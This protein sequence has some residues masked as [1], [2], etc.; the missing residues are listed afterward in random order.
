MCAVAAHVAAGRA[1]TI[2]LINGDRI[3]G[4]VVGQNDTSLFVR[5]TYRDSSIRYVETIPRSR[6]ARV[7]KTGDGLAAP[8]IPP[9]TLPAEE[10]KFSFS[11]PIDKRLVL[12]TA[13][14]KWNEGNM[15][16]AGNELTR[17]IT[18]SS[19]EE[20][21]A[22]SR[23]VEAK[24]KLSLGEMAARAHWEAAHDVRSGRGVHFPTA[25]RYELPYLL[26][27]L[28]E[29]YEAALQEEITVAP[30][31]RPG[32]ATPSAQR[33][34]EVPPYNRLTIANYLDRPHELR[35]SKAEANVL[36]AHIQYATSLLTERMRLDPEV[37]QNRTLHAA[38]TGQRIRLVALM[39]AASRLVLAPQDRARRERSVAS[40]PAEAAPRPTEPAVQQTSPLQQD[41]L[42]QQAIRLAREQEEAAAAG[43]APVPLPTGA[44]PTGLQPPPAPPSP[45]SQP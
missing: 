36:V 37:R 11:P 19:P 20:L 45:P 31:T 17:L 8:F 41:T 38:L 18:N 21:E 22:F 34:A 13:L 32:A 42:L 30:T 43:A 24:T 3:Q 5:R 16:A 33:A 28:I 40:R 1:D 27:R 26:P 44:Q 14:I 12:H 15:A 2:V 25:T 4:E 10:E 6:V 35:C 39:R 29:A 23:E 9:T 7:E